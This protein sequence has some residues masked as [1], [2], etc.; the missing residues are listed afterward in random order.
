ML[1][2]IVGAF[3]NAVSVTLIGGSYSHL[4]SILSLLPFGLFLVAIPYLATTPT[5][6]WWLSTAM[7]VGAA[8]LVMVVLSVPAMF[9]GS[10]IGSTGGD[11]Y[12]IV[13][14]WFLGACLG[15]AAL[16]LLSFLLGSLARYVVRSPRPDGSVR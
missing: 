12:F 8:W 2:G 7:T 9:F 13:A 14:H 4:G 10:W 15:V 6:D 3:W 5:H 16:A 1:L 11:T